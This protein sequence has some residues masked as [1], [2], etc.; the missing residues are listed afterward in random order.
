MKYENRIVGGSK[1]VPLP[2]DLL[3]CIGLYEALVCQEV[4]FQVD[5]QAYALR[6][7]SN[8]TTGVRVSSESISRKFRGRIS[9]ST[10]RTAMQNLK[11]LGI[12]VELEA[13]SGV[14][15]A[16]VI[17]DH[18]RA[19]QVHKMGWDAAQA[20][21]AESRLLAK[22]RKSLT[23]TADNKNH[24]PDT[25]NQIADTICQQETVTHIIP[26]K[27]NNK[28]TK[29]ELANAICSETQNSEPIQNEPHLASERKSAE[30]RT[31]TLPTAEE[32][33][34]TKAKA[35]FANA[36]RALGIEIE[37]RSMRAAF[38][39]LLAHAPHVAHSANQGAVQE[40]LVGNGY[41]SPAASPSAPQQ[42]RHSGSLTKP[43][44]QGI[45][46]EASKV[47][48]SDKNGTPIPRHIGMGFNFDDQKRYQNGEWFI[49]QGTDAHG[50]PR[51][52]WS[53]ERPKK[54][55]AADVESFM[56]RFSVSKEKAQAMLGVGAL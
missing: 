28:N 39:A 54:I 23:N 10:V 19:S 18:E 35:I 11:M 40:W 38:E 22:K 44:H 30:T 14:Q 3:E 36:W 50:V 42:P 43:W 16:L 25:V 29:P 12:I 1:S 31:N 4:T 15:S 53:K 34:T 13:A 55:T 2:L 56:K 9:A 46:I 26:N 7:E 48:S 21:L 24:L 41:A 33:A 8:L 37:P 20:I 27:N 6:N 45:P 52:E 47:P 49:D 32:H 17:V 51:W 5:R